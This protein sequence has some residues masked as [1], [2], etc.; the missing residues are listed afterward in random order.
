MKNQSMETNLVGIFKALLNRQ[1]LPLFFIDQIII[2]IYILLFIIHTNLFPVIRLPHQQRWTEHLS[3]TELF[4]F[5]SSLVL[6]LNFSTLNSSIWIW[7]PFLLLW[8]WPLDEI[9]PCQSELLLVIEISEQ[10]RHLLV[11]PHVS[12]IHLKLTETPPHRYF[13]L[14][15]DHRVGICKKNYQKMW[16]IVLSTP[17]LEVFWCNFPGSESYKSRGK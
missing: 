10:N 7:S 11:L 6:D 12:Q 9:F 16:Y 17:K 15:T 14:F 1:N 13:H 5:S 8:G 4:P 2:N 3:I